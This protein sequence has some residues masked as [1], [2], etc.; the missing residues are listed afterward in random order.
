VDLNRVTQ[1]R[2][3]KLREGKNEAL[4]AWFDVQDLI[5]RI[6]KRGFNSERELKLSS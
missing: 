5:G 4:G 2:R 6:P 3:R 1:S